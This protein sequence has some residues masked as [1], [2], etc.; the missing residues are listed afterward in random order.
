MLPIFLSPIS[1]GEKLTNL[2][3]SIKTREI[4]YACDKC[5]FSSNSANG[6]KTHMTKK[7]KNKRETDKSKFPQECSLCDLI[8]N[9]SNEE[10]KH[11]RTHSY[12][13]VQFECEICDFKGGAKT[14]MEVHVAKLHVEKIECG[15]CEYEG[16]DQGDLETHLL[17]CEYY[18][19][20]ACT[21]KILQFSN[22]KE[23]LLTKHKEVN[24]YMFGVDHVKPSRENCELYS[25]TF[26]SFISLF[27]EFDN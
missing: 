22:I 3:A 9:D 10:K 4:K 23:H 16:K 7:H 18:D 6:L 15:I 1:F 21:G 26:H 19:C 13:N 27:P 24:K 17:T 2:E 25:K 12:K 14:D 20:E 11:M 8:L 5:N